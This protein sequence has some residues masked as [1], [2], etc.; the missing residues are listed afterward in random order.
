MLFVLLQFE[1]KNAP[2]GVAGNSEPP[3]KKYWPGEELDED[4]DKTPTK[5]TKPADKNTAKLKVT[6]RLTNLKE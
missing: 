2:L 4:N 5:Q 6:T 3:K 1:G